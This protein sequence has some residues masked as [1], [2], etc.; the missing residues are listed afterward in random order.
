M[1]HPPSNVLRASG[2]TSPGGRYFPWILALLS[3]ALGLASFGLQGR[4][5]IPN[6]DEGQL[7]YVSSKIFQGKIPFVDFQS[8]SPGR[9]YWNAFWMFLQGG[10]GLLSFRFAL[11]LF[12]ALAVFFGLMALARFWNYLADFA[13]LGLILVLWSIQRYRV[14]EFSWGLIGVYVCFW[15][16][17]HPKDPRKF[18]LLGAFTGLSLWI[19]FNLGF[20]ALCSF[21]LLGAFLALKPQTRPSLGR[22][23][24]AT[25]L[26][27]AGA[28]LPMVILGL[29]VP[30]FGGRLFDFIQKILRKGATNVQAPSPWSWH[31]L[32]LGMGWIPFLSHLSLGLLLVLIPLFYLSTFFHSFRMKRPL[33]EWLQLRLSAAVVGLPFFHYPVSRMDWE[34]LA[35]A[36]P[37]FLL[38][39]L[40]SPTLGDVAKNRVRLLLLL[41]ASLCIAG[42]QSYLY[43]KWTAPPGDFQ[44][45]SVDG[46]DFDVPSRTAAFAQNFS[47]WAQKEMNPSGYLLAAPMACNIYPLYHLESPVWE[48]YF[49]WPASPE[50]ERD[51][52]RDL[53][54]K[55]VDWALLSDFALEGKDD[56]RLHNTHPLL[57]RYLMDH[58]SQVTPGDLEKG[59][60]LFRRKNGGERPAR[61]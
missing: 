23:L 34:H 40:G 42:P 60:Y 37:P 4:I 3:L 46:E 15:V 61:P 26:G 47:H 11:C 48:L 30:G 18:M 24:P 44:V 32:G 52:I 33:P 28:L 41:A 14:F 1:K 21:I 10:P 9:Y 12:Q 55:K 51:E 27:L 20:Y 54:T 6:A 13:L 17:R 56:Y 29:G 38:W 22:I 5:D 16:L 57:W 45:L 19:G 49:T 7:W 2:F 36:L 50:L 39:V 43:E 8:Y 25:L 59:Y 35:A 58:F 31:S 53:E